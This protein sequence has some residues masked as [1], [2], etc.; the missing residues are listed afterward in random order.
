MI[1]VTD[2]LLEEYKPLVLKKASTLYLVG[3]DRYD[4]IQEGMIGLYKAIRDYDESKGLPFPTF[5]DIC[6]TRQLYSAIRA[7]SAKKNN[8]LNTFVEWNEENLDSSKSA[9]EIVV[10][11]VNAN[12]LEKEIRK[13]LSKF[14][15]QVMDL[16]LEKPDYQEIAVKLGKSTKTIDNAIQRIR[17]KARAVL[18]E[19]DEN[20]KE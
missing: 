7:D 11:Q 13:R 9:E 18:E 15:E 2:A 6:I 4:L 1:N 19:R 16:Y 10:D 14:E 12:D 3:G 5:A 20:E 8:P 17:T